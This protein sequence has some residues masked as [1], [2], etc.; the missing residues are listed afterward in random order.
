MERAVWQL[1]EHVYRGK[2]SDV[3]IAALKA[4]QRS[5]GHDGVTRIY[6]QAVGEF[7]LSALR[8]ALDDNPRV[9]AQAAHGGIELRCRLRSHLTH[10]L[11]RCLMD[12]GHA[13]ERMRDVHFSTD[14][15]L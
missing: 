14:L 8:Q 7:G 4:F 1:A 13:T 10:F 11:R 9:W 5:P 6:A 2:L 15:G 12:D 3:L